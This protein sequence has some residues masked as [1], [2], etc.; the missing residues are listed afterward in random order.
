IGLRCILI[1]LLALALA[2]AN[3]R[4][5]NDRLTVLFLWDRSLSIPQEFEGGRDLREERIKKFINDSVAQRGPGHERDLAGL[6]VF[7][8]WPR[9]ELPP[10]DAPQFRLHKIASAVDDTHTDIAAA[11][12]LALASFPEG[13][14]K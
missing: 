9:L 8:R 5:P 13:T 4:Q 12:K 7:G 6:I 2:E 14:G 10:S 1:A 11:I 3:A